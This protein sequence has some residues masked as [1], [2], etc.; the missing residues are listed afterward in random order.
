MG[1]RDLERQ[2]TA[3]AREV[4][5]NKKLRVIEWSTRAR[6]GGHCSSSEAKRAANGPMVTWWW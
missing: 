6:V 3:E 2:I 5:K 4:F 1:M